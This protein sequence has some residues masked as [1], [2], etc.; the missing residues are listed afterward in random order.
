M[1]L[2]ARSLISASGI[3]L[4]LL[5]PLRFP[6]FYWYI[7]AG[8]CLLATALVFWIFGEKPSFKSL[9]EDW[10][11]IIFLIIFVANS[12]TFAYL[13]QHPL[14][15][16]LLLGSVGLFV[17]FIYIVASRLKKGYSPA[18]F[19]KNVISISTIL[20]IFYSVA[21]ALR[22]A[23]T[24]DVRLSQLFILAFTF[25][26][27]FVVCEFLFEVQGIEKSLLYSLT[28]AFAITQIV[29][30]SSYWTVN[31]PSSEKLA[32]IGVPLPAVISG[33]FF[34]LF[35]GLSHHR[36]EGNLTRKVIIE[37]ILISGLFFGILMLTT[38]WLP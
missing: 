28:L 5:L 4:A 37:Y 26:S 31:Y 30:I 20:A 35:W 9:K 27:V 38:K 17:Y 15:E 13:A 25:I 10:F 22:Y 14:V 1:E 16:A 21:N 32:L 2:K 7:L 12:A 8:T 36:L 23:L 29:W 18:L 34:Y 24:V 3:F 33:V 6:E 19:L 11:T